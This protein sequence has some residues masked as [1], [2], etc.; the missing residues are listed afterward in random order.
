MRIGRTT[1]LAL[2]SACVC[3]PVLPAAAKDPAG[4]LGYLD[5]RTGNFHVANLAVASSPDAAGVLDGTFKLTLNIHAVT[6]SSTVSCSLQV[7][8]FSTTG[9]IE[10]TA[11]ATA[12]V[13]GGNATCD[14]TLPYSWRGPTVSASMPISVSYTIFNG[15][16]QRISTQG[17][18]SLTKAPA[19]GGT[20]S[21]TIAATI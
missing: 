17:V 19:N 1:V 13:S 4:I 12:S 9:L 15:T 5:P 16:S 8:L 2:V 20:T 3:L 18:A 11:G 14:V 7:T 6:P 21:Y 10:E